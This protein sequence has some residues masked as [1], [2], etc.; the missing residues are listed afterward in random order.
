MNQQ[1]AADQLPASSGALWPMVVGAAIGC[2]TTDAELRFTA[3]DGAGIVQ[4]MGEAPGVV[5]DRSIAEG[6]RR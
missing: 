3:M 5:V 2:W 6:S 4:A 1:L